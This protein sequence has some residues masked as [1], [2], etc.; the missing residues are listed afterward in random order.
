VQ[1]LKRAVAV[2]RLGSAII[3]AL[4]A[5]L[6]ILLLTAAPAS[7][8]DGTSPVSCPTGSSCL[9]Q[10]Q[11]Q[12]HLPGSGSGST[13]TNVKPTCAWD[14]V[15]NAQT[16][17]QYIVS[18]YG[19][20]APAQDAPYGQYASYQQARQ[21]LASDYTQSGEWYTLAQRA[22][23][24]T[25]PMWIFAVPGEV[26]PGGQLTGLTLAQLA[27]ATI[28]V[29]GA[30]QVVLSPKGNSYSN[31]PTYVQVKLSGSYEIGP[32]GMPYV[33]GTANVGNAA[34]TIWIEPDG[35][36]S[37]GS[38]D[39]SYEP[40]TNGCGYLGST[41]IALNKG[42]VAST[43]RNGKPDCGLTFYQP[44]S[45]QLTAQLNWRTCWEAEVVY[46]PPPAQCTPV[47]GA[48]LNP[49]TW[50]RTVPVH[51]VQADTGTGT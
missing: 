22:Q 39:P 19:G 35:T 23:C 15:G 5:L 44:G 4:V 6:S 16:G 17:S 30:G 21:M 28:R 31:L 33:R 9:I 3:G 45:W 14:P 7:A 34:A 10:L 40:N 48:I 41:M 37:L 13:L 42:T 26:L 2:T 8:A 25:E 1:A 38:N 11:Q 36:L 12:A 24:P 47:P 20:S 18:H 46:G 43:G 29:P 27:T 50:T 32:G 49:T 51:E